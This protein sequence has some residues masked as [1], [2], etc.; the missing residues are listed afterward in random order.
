MTDRVRYFLTLDAGGTM[1]DCYLSDEEGNGYIG[2]SLT[3]PENQA[4]S[5]LE[6]VGDA[7]QEA[8]VTRSQVHAGTQLAIYAGTTM[9][10]LV[11]T[12]TGAK[13]GL[14]VTRGFEHYPYIERGL[15]WLGQTRLEQAKWQ[16]HEHTAPLVALRHVKGISERILGG[17]PYRAGPALAEGRVLIPL[18]ERE[19]EA[20]VHYFLDEGIESIGI[21]F[22]CSYTNPSH[23]QQAQA[24]AER[25]IAER[26]RNVPVVISADICA[27]REESTR[28]KSVL[29]ECYGA[30]HTR[31]Q[32]L[33]V[34]EAARADHYPYELGTLLLYGAVANI[35]HPRLY[36]T[37]VSGPI[38][39]IL[40]G[41]ALAD[42]KGWKNVVCCDLGGTTFDVGAIVDGLLPVARSLDF[43]RHRLNAPALGIDS[44]GSGAGTEIHVDAHYKRLTLGPQSAG[45]QVGMCLNHPDITVAD[46]DLV[47]GYLSPDN[48]LGGRVKLDR[49]KALAALE[50][51]L[52]R[53][54][55][56]DVYEACEGVL[57]MIHDSLGD[58]INGSL[59]SRGLS[60]GAY[61]LLTYG[62]SGP[63]HLWGVAERVEAAAICTVPWAAAFSA[64]GISV[65]ES[66]SRIE[67]TV[68]CTLSPGLA[69]DERL[70]EAQK[71]ATAWRE[72]EGQAYDELARVGISK[73]TIHF[74]YG[75]SARYVGQLF[76]SW[77]AH[78][79]RGTVETQHDVD[80]LIDSFEKEFGRI[81]PVAGR[82]P[83]AGY[84]IDGAFIE[85]VVD[86]RAPI[87]RQF[88][89]GD[90]TPDPA[91][92]KGQRKAYWKK[93]WFDFDLWDMDSLR[94]GNVVE[95][96]AIIEHSMTTF[97]IPPGKRAE[98]DEHQVLW[99]R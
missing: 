1:T 83:E 92:S 55:G 63:L 4:E 81:Y 52:A 9:T 82:F 6:S 42:V 24:I 11:I 75:I 13:V 5:Y 59:L 40:G 80:V 32:L 50:E 43:A 78:V 39:G 22:L 16:L 95:G 51:R 33:A 94:A 62:G 99:Y 79:P 29:I 45:P 3:V 90:K 23:E 73:E 49:D 64:W 8:G 41:K 66:F 96:P 54:L 25:V 12:G 19:V 87:I 77:S 85:A 10:N 58:H 2:K 21:V 44:I 67:K 37:V 14:L 17:S 91:A 48:F 98:W 76:V 26:G 88:A 15:T 56:I 57:D 60:P 61:V 65:A 20:A 18:N 97:V 35:R 70:Q 30:E 71:V 38:G 28:M 36:E 72:L 31:T 47:L 89:L 7:A 34:E 84:Q 86:K 74:R 68:V 69:P 46:V 53:P 93:D 27:R